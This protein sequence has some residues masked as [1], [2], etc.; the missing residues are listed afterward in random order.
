MS[1][2]DE[3]DPFIEHL[4]LQAPRM[5]DSADFVRRVDT[6]LTSG[7]RIRRMVIAAA[8]LIGGVF[9]VRETLGANLRFSAS[10]ESAEAA[11]SAGPSSAPDAARLMEAG[12]SVVAAQIQALQDGFGRLGVDYDFL[13]MGGM[14][15]FW[16]MTALLIAVAVIV[17][18]KLASE[19]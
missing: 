10:G 13:S 5:A 11:L 17:G 7:S 14:Q 18:M 19:V 12:S 6:R 8:G 1:A 15:G 16:I 4:F 2:P 9:A 3:F